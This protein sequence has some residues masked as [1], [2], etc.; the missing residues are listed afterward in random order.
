H[1]PVLYQEAG[2]QRQPVAGHFVVDSGRVTFDVGSYDH[3]RSLVIDPLVLG[4]STYLGGTGRDLG[5]GIA[6]DG[7]GAA[8]VVGQTLSTNFPTPPGA[9]DTSY[10]GGP[11]YGDAFVAKVNAAG[12]GLAY[13]TYLGGVDDDYADGIA[14]DAAGSAYVT[15]STASK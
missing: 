9:F 6:V 14:V 11:S 7:K 8:Y 12:N 15:G 4:Y 1:A 3:S 2:S 5:Y 13:S 10:N